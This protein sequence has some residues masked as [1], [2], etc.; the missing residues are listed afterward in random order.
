M[1]MAVWVMVLFAATTTDL[2]RAASQGDTQAIRALVAAG[3]SVEVQNDRNL[4][5]LHF[6]AMKGHAEAVKALVHKLY[7]E[8]AMRAGKLDEAHS[9]LTMALNTCGVLR[10]R[11]AVLLAELLHLRADVHSLRRDQESAA[12]DRERAEQLLLRRQVEYEM[13]GGFRPA[14]QEQS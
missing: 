12:A 14:R 6:A 3:A 5:P 7:A 2:H 13:E 10:L 11:G 8:R 4:T 9:L 1:E